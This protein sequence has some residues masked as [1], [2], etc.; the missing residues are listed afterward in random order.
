[1]MF[2]T[3]TLYN[4]TGSDMSDVNQQTKPTDTDSIFHGER[5]DSV[6]STQKLPLDT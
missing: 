1:M 2:T 4:I 3:I 6:S 5:P